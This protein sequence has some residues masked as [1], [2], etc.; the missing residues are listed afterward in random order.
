MMPVDCAA[1]VGRV[2]VGVYL[3]CQDAL[4]AQQL[5]HLAD[6]RAALQQVGRKAV[7]QSVGTDGFSDAGRR[8]RLPQDSEYHHPRE[9]PAPDV[10]KQG[11]GG[12]A[13]VANGHPGGDPVARRA[14]HRHQTLFV[15]L[16]HHTHESVV[17]K[18]VAQPHPHK[19]RYATFGKR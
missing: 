4:V 8:S 2:E 1:Q 3:G 7:T 17:E 12:S 16:T 10:E 6:A 9:T 15:A 19:L 13:P 18:E 11:V 5:L 14:A